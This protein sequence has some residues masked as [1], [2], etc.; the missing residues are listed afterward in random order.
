MEGAWV[1]NGKTIALF[2]WGV[3]GGIVDKKE[4]L[5]GNLVINHPSIKWGN[6]RVVVTNVS[7]FL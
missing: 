7:P 1:T 5:Q 4:E 6:S 3:K 2:V